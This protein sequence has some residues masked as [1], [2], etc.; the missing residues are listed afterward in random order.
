MLPTSV[1]VKD[2][3]QGHLTLVKKAIKGEQLVRLKLDVVKIV[4]HNFKSLCIIYV[5]KILEKGK[6]RNS[7]LEVD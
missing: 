1:V 2:W 5:L 6:Q 7:H 3:Q 4:S